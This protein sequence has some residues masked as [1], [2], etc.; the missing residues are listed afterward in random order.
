M[1]P[2]L[3]RQTGSRRSESFCRVLGSRVQGPGPSGSRYSSGSDYGL[4]RDLDSE[5]QEE[6]ASVLCGQF[7]KRGL[8]LC[9]VHLRAMERRFGIAAIL[10]NFWQ[11]VIP[12]SLGI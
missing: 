6:F 10:K 9:I 12:T 4:G 7:L 2:L 5:R 11:L 1:G 3:L 8:L